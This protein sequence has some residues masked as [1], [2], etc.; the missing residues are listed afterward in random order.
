MT[1]DYRPRLSIEISDQQARE[2]RDLI[3]WGLRKQL[4]TVIVED[5]IRLTRK[6]GH[7]FIAAVIA[8]KIQLADYSSM[9][10]PTDAD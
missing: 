1:T 2:L 9:E 5:V 8:G 10:V 3:P 6:Y 7:T 4:F